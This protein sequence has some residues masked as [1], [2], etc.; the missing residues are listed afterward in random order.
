[1]GKKK[2]F[3]SGF[4]KSS[5][6]IILKFKKKDPEDREPFEN[7]NWRNYAKKQNKVL[8]NLARKRGKILLRKKRSQ[9]EHWSSSNKKKSR[10]K[11]LPAVGKRVLPFFKKR[12]FKNSLKKQIYWEIYPH[13]WKKKAI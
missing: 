1:M 9:L 13:I 3:H 5:T 6:K 12:N 11:F 4:Q 8:K 2:R 7:F 10:K